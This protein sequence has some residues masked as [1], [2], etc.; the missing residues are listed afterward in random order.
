VYDRNQHAIAIYD[1][2]TGDSK[3]I[4]TVIEEPGL[5]DPTG[6]RLVYAILVE[7]PQEFYSSFALAD[8]AN[9]QG[10]VHALNEPD[11]PPVDDHQAA[12]NPD[13]KSLAVTRRYLDNRQV[14]GPQVYLVN[15]DTGDA[16]P[17]VVEGSYSHGAIGWNP[18]GDQLV[19]QRFPCM[20]QN[21]QPGIWVYDMQ[22][23]T[24]RQVAK[25]GYVPQW[26]P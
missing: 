20:E 8:L 18:A 6:Q 3:L 16:Q 4:P 9:P 24:L 1:L 13:G 15:P 23:K 5:F 22:G 12:W 2:T 10:S 26:L 11:A 17:L 21:A 19:M 25:N 14:C 7:A